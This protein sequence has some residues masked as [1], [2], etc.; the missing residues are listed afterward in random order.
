MGGMT[1]APQSPDEIRHACAARIVAL[2]DAL[3]GIP[4]ELAPCSRARV[5][6]VRE[7][8]YFGWERPMAA[9]RGARYVAS[10]YE[11]DG[12]WSVGAARLVN[13]GGYSPRTRLLE[14]EHVEPVSRVVNDLLAALR[15]VEETADLLEARLVTCTVLADEHRRLGPGGGWDRYTAAG[16]AVQRGLA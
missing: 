4:P 14:R 3:R 12:W 13:T 1:S 10:K 7:Q 16:I 5:V 9:A 2:V 8:I 6:A 15:T 11:V